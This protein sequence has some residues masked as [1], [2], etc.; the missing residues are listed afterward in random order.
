MTEAI[1]LLAGF[2]QEDLHPEETQEAS[3]WKKQ[4]ALRI[5]L[6]EMHKAVKA[7]APDREKAR[8]T[9]GHPVTVQETEPAVPKTRTAK[10]RKATAAEALAAVQETV[11]ETDPMIRKTDPAVQKIQ[12]LE[13]EAPAEAVLEAAIRK[14]TLAEAV[15][16]AAI[17]KEALAEAVPEAAIRREAP[18]EAVPEAEARK[19]A[20][21]PAVIRLTPDIFGNISQEREPQSQSD[22]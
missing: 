22:T 6:R 14:E 3:I 8:R 2:L 1:R 12:G 13:A 4:R 9:A 5:R 18:A 7:K 15:L 21:D 19:T 16:E 17:R 11:Q 20:E 10:K